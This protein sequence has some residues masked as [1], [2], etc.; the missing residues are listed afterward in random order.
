MVASTFH[1]ENTLRV[2]VESLFGIPTM[3]FP[4]RTTSY[5]GEDSAKDSL[6]LLS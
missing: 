1:G 6:V 5:I 4:V 3:A 2:S